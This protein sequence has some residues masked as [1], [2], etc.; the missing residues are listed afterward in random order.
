[1][2]TSYKLK[3]QEELKAM[4][5]LE[6]AAERAAAEAAEM[7]ARAK[8]AATDARI[9]EKLSRLSG[10]AIAGPVAELEP[11]L[12]EEKPK[13]KIAAKKTLA[14]KATTKRTKK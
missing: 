3:F 5:R 13:K 2:T 1:M 6:R 4:K 8:K 14:K 10:A 9:A 12:V 7:Q 11:V